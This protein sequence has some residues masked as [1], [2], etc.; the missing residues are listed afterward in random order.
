MNTRRF[1]GLFAC[2]IP[3]LITSCEQPEN[4]VE[5]NSTDKQIVTGEAED[6]TEFSVK[7]KSIANP[8]PEMG[9]VTLG[10]LISTS[11]EFSKLFSLDLKSKE[12]DSMNQFTVSTSEL[13]PNTQYYYKAYI[14]YGGIYHYGEV[15]S[16]KTLE[17]NIQVV[18][19][20]VSDITDSSAV[21]H[22]HLE[23]NIKVNKYV[24]FLMSPS[25][26]GP[27]ES[28]HQYSASLNDDGT[29][30]KEVSDL[31]CETTYYC[32]A[33]LVFNGQTMQGETVS[34]TTDKKP[35]PELKLN[36][37]W[38]IEYTGRGSKGGYPVDYIKT[39]NVSKDQTYFVSVI[40]DEQFGSYDGDLLQFFKTELCNKGNYYYQKSS[41]TI[42]FDPFRHGLWYAFIIAVD[43]KYWL[44][45]W[46]VSDGTI[47]YNITITPIEANY[48]YRLDGW[49]VFQGAQEQMTSEYLET[50]FDNGKMY[51]VSQFIQSYEEPDYGVAKEYF[52]GQIDYMGTDYLYVLKSEEVDLAV[53]SLINDNTA[54]LKPCSVTFNV[55]GYERTGVVY[56]MQYY[57][58]I[59]GVIYHYNDYPQKLPCTME[60]L[61][62]GSSAP[63]IK[64][65]GARPLRAKIHNED[66]GHKNTR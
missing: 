16:F 50:F 32:T 61:S 35:D 12:L 49:E 10:V 13:K 43:S 51:F 62:G 23:G 27:G 33:E 42:L 54:Q 30:S 14:E 44:G 59:K 64:L 48:V 7:I 65:R 17:L 20:K 18:T 5:G 56:N 38:K 66:S 31:N 2:L 36:T 58:I 55:D 47:E 40:N 6:I 19:D 15:K 1:L 46:K 29:F 9:T 45:N 21:F 3:L 11:A 37:Q 60:R 26:Y 41:E 57:V 8:T 52:F 53:A 25:P 22:G 4:D 34:F 39:S 24:S 63:T 28:V